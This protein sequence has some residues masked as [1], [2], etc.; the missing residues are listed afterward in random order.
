MSKQ[1]RNIII[2]VVVVL[3]LAGGLLLIKMLPEEQQPVNE[4]STT[5][6]SETETTTQGEEEIITQAPEGIYLT[7]NEEG[8]LDTI[9]VTNEHGTYKLIQ[10]QKNMW[11]VDGYDDLLTD[12]EVPFLVDSCA[13]FKVASVVDGNCTDFSKYGLTNPKVTVRITF[14]DGSEMTV[15]FGDVN[16]SSSTKS[17]YL[18]VKNGKEVYEEAVGLYTAF[19][20][21]L[22]ELFSTEMLSPQR[23][24]DT[25]GKTAFADIDSIVLG[26]TARDKEIIITANQFYGKQNS[27]NLI[28]K[29]SK[30]TIT[31]P[32][33]IPLDISSETGRFGTTYSRLTETGIMA[34]SVAKV[35]PTDADKAKFGLAEPAYTVAITS[36]GKKYQF[37]FSELNVQE[38]V[39][40]ATDEFG[41]IIFCVNQTNGKWITAT[42]DELATKNLYVG[43]PYQ[44]SKV[45]VKTENASTAFN[46]TQLGDYEMTVKEGNREVDAAWFRRFFDIVCELDWVDVAEKVPTIGG[47]DTVLEIRVEYTADTGYAQDVIT[48]TKCS[49]RRYLIGVNGKGA[50]ACDTNGLNSILKAYEG[51]MG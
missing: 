47:R 27:G 10:P 46:V 9:E 11:I 3:L 25:E 39:Y 33:S 8:N 15:Y 37:Y 2:T 43:D 21:S 36:Q 28:F 35:H 22:E 18:Y 23:I 45:T 40:Y 1:I 24:T 4:E 14:R 17:R 31:S 19:S 32:I 16:P 44:L 51:L 29:E 34:S 13:N 20:N 12:D 6:N 50:F 42:L 49:P 5:V 38:G 26:G 7:Q 41:M 48:L 30:M